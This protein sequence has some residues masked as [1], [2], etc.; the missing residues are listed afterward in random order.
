MQRSF[1]VKFVSASLLAM[2]IVMY[3]LPSWSCGPFPRYAYFSYTLHPDFPLTKFA[4]GDLGIIQPTYARSYLVVAYRYLSGKSLSATQQAAFIRLWKARLGVQFG[5]NGSNPE[6]HYGDSD[7]LK[8]WLSLRKQIVGGADIQI[9]T[10]RHISTD[11]NVYNGIE[12]CPDEAFKGAV[13]TLNERIAKYGSKSTFV[14]EW[15]KGQDNVFCH[16]GS[17]KYD[18]DTKQLAPEGPFPE[19]APP[20]ADAL[21]RADRAYQI[22][23]AHFYAMQYDQAESEFR[24]IAQDKNSSWQRLGLYMAARSL[25]RKGTIS[26][27]INKEALSKASQLLE[28]IIQDPKLEALHDAASGLQEFIAGQTEPAKRLLEL[29]RKMFESKDLPATYK[30]IY[31]YI[32]LLD[33]FIPDPEAGDS[34]ALSPIKPDQLEQ[35]DL[36]D[37]LLTF[38]SPVAQSH[39]IERWRKERSL[40]WL[41]ASLS[42][43]DRQDPSHQDVI[44]AARSISPSSPAYATV[45]FHLAR[46][47]LSENHL[48]DERALLKKISATKLSPSAK[49]CFMDMQML[50]ASSMKEFLPFAIRH[51]AGCFYTYGAE[52][53]DELQKLFDTKDY[54]TAGSAC[55]VP[56]AA[57]MLN[58]KTPLKMLIDAAFTSSV[59]S[60]PRFDLAQAAWVRAILLNKRNVALSLVPI[61]KTLRPTL[62]KLYDAYAYATNPADQQFAAYFLILKNPGS[63]PYVTAGAPRQDD[64]SRLDDYGDNWWGSKDTTSQ[65]QPAPCTDPIMKSH[66]PPFLTAN[67]LKIAAAEV[68]TIIA[69]G[70]APNI[71]T[72]HVLDYARNHPHDP[73]LPEALHRC[74]RATRL[75]STDKSTT[76]FSRRAFV[77]L[78]KQYGN[79]AWA[80]KTPYYY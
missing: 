80:K 64:Y 33:R 63:R 68:A 35:D 31:D 11:P 15:I 74:V 23:A 65:D 60:V 5:D 8:A 51:P 77:L 71:L 42:S 53:P 22:A 66:L 46:L 20:D 43:M 25:V 16:C 13:K 73:R 24:A 14:K 21:F 38:R 45:S 52:C 6:Y 4:A 40:A 72:A 27:P 30:T 37:W 70:E 59:A 75:G 41:I 69:L 28:E 17:R 36:T 26:D 62:S 57:N 79:N 12:N 39:V 54:A 18:Y 50:L 34:N 2:V 47:F 19:T 58:L 3:L 32:F 49:S 48:A 55:I 7:A 61:L 67:D 78:H 44:L 29:S 1:A 76:S 10:Y 9:Q 56:T